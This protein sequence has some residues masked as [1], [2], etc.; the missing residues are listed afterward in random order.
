MGSL[1]DPGTPV[2]APGELTSDVQSYEHARV[3]KC[4]DN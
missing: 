2:C 4:L 1:G 3:L